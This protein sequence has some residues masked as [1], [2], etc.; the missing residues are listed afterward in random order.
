MP[1][2]YETYSRS[3][4]VGIYSGISFVTEM[5]Q[6]RGEGLQA[7]QLDSHSSQVSHV[8]CALSKPGNRTRLGDALGHG[9]KYPTAVI[10][11]QIWNLPGI[12]S[13]SSLRVRPVNVV[14]VILHEK[15]CTG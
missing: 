8:I 7:F 15:G 14:C 1:S 2:E 3:G 9:R 5:L 6:L 11:G 10:R 4:D 12:N 13:L